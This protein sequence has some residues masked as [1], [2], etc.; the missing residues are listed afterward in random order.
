[1]YT[2][3]WS[4]E[5]DDVSP[6]GGSLGCCWESRQAIAMEGRRGKTT[7]TGRSGPP[8][9]RPTNL[10][11]ALAVL[12]LIVL[13]IPMAFADSSPEATKWKRSAQN[14]DVS[15]IWITYYSTT[16]VWPPAVTATTPLGLGSS[17]CTE[18]DPAV[19]PIVEGRK[20]GVPP[21][22]VTVA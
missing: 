18:A 1:M 11:G 13:L 19:C 14:D 5:F 2:W 7:T 22:V 4:L 12:L 10:G 6:A 17:V 16:T 8:A 21:H 15:P 3:T 9:L 20:T